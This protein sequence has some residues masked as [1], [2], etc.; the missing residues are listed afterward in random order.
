MELLRDR[1]QGCQQLKTLLLNNVLENRDLER[2]DSLQKRR[3]RSRGWSA[4]GPPSMRPP[5]D[6]ERSTELDSAMDSARG[7]AA[8]D[9]A[10]GVGPLTPRPLQV[11]ISDEVSAASGLRQTK[12]FGSEIV[13]E[14]SSDV[15]PPHRQASPR[16]RMNEDL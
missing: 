1:V 10:D 9:A 15:L 12:R 4:F 14:Q 11:Q 7:D 13:T 3:G 8:S 6:S 2:R 16:T 5:D